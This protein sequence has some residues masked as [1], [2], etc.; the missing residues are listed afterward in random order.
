MRRDVVECLG[1]IVVEVRSRAA[2]A[3]QRRDLERV[4]VLERRILQRVAAAGD[5]RP[6]R[7]GS[8]Q[9]RL[10]GPGLDKSA[11]IVGLVNSETPT[12]MKAGLPESARR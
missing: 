4:D 5:D 3:A 1:G 12:L 2:D 6:A 7:V 11:R 10:V 8:D 9:V